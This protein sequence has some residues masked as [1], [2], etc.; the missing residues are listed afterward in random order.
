MRYC[1]C[2]RSVYRMGTT[3]WTKPTGPEA[4]VIYDHKLNT[5]CEF[6]DLTEVLWMPID[7]V[8]FVKIGD[9]EVIG[10]APETLFG[11]DTYNAAHGCLTLLEF[12]INDVDVECREPPQTRFRYTSDHRCSRPLPPALGF[13]IAAQATPHAEGTGSLYPAEGRDNKEILLVTARHV[14]SHQTA[15]ENLVKIKIRIGRYG[16]IERLQE[17]LAAEDDNDVEEAAEK[18]RKIQISLDET[19]RAMDALGRLHDEVTKK[20]SHPSQHVLGHI[21]RS[22]PIT[23]GA[24]TE[25]FAEDYAVVKIDSS[26]LGKAFKGNVIDLGTKIPADEFTWKIIRI[27]LRDFIQEDQMCKLDMLEHDGESFLKSGVFSTLGSSGSIIVDGRGRI[28]GL[29]TG[30]AG[31]ESLDISYAT[32]FSW[33]FPRNKN[34]GLPGAHFY[35]VVV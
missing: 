23:V 33:L 21:I 6:L 24:G 9:G 30:G 35:P 11:K 2:P 15:F 29:L 17:R 19:N 20:W 7:V 32:P 12:G 26:K 27:K 18:L 13:F 5:A 34:S 8:S 22:P 1:G 3:P 25:G 4:S 28:G 31:K 16:T 14:S 10:V